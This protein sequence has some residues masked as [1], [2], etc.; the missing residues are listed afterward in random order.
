MFAVVPQCVAA[1]LVLL[2]LAQPIVCVV[3]C[4]VANA[5]AHNVA[6]G[7]DDPLSFFLC[8][9]QEPTAAHGL[10]LLAFWPGALPQLVLGASTLLLLVTLV[11]SLPARYAP[12]PAKPLAPPPR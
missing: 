5:P 8:V 1:L 12:P 7:A 2:L 6:S 3:H 10:F 4:W 11:A 9:H